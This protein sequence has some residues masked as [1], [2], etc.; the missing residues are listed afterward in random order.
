M[1]WSWD[2]TEALPT[3]IMHDLYVDETS[4]AGEWAGR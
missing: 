4:G 2:T 3:A 1:Y